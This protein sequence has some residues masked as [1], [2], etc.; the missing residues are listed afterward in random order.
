MV[1]WFCILFFFFTLSLGIFD[2]FQLCGPGC[3]GWCGLWLAFVFSVFVWSN[4]LSDGLTGLAAL[5]GVP[6][7]TLSS[8]EGTE[9]DSVGC[10]CANSG[11]LVA[12]SMGFSL[13]LSRASVSLAAVPVGFSVASAANLAAIAAAKLQAGTYAPIS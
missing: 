13:L 7:T 1:L 3:V 10:N 2:R 12:I 8:V 6:L 9:T 5:A 11:W 4:G